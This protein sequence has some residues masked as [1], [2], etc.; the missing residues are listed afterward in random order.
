MLPLARISTA[1]NGASAPVPK[2]NSGQASSPVVS[3]CGISI[4]VGWLTNSAG[5]RNGG[6]VPNGY[7]LLPSGTATS[8]SDKS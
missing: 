5:A 3:C 1:R 2:L 6:D 4:I 7:G 8:C